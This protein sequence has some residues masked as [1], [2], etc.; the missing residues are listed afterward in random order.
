[1][2]EQGS[3]IVQGVMVTTLPAVVSL[4]VVSRSV[5]SAQALI[6][7]RHPTSW[8]ID[9][10]AV[11]HLD[12]SAAAPV[13]ASLTA[14]KAAGGRRVAVSTTMPMVKLAALSASFTT[15]LKVKVFDTRAEAERWIGLKAAG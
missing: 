6:A 3:R 11:T 5:A 8:L 2:S 9:G 1:M 7:A 4:D 10:E 12:T 15:G 13:Q 14:F